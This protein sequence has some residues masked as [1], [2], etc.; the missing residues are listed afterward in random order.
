MRIVKNFAWVL[1]I[2]GFIVLA[3]LIYGGKNKQTGHIA[4]NPN[5]AIEIVSQT[6]FEERLAALKGNAVLLNFWA[7][8]CP[9]CVGEV[10]DLIKLH[11]KY[12]TKGFAVIGFS[13]D[14]KPSDFVREFA[15]NLGITYPVYYS[16][17]SETIA[18]KY[19]FTNAIPF[20]VIFDAAGKPQKTFLGARSYEE[21]ESAILAFLPEK[22]PPKSLPPV[23]MAANKHEEKYDVKVAIVGARSDAR[24]AGLIEA[25]EIESALTGLKA[26]I[27]V[28]DPAIPDDKK[29]IEKDFLE[30]TD[31]P[32]A[33]ACTNETCFPPT[34]DPAELRKFIQTALKT[35]NEK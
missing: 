32:T 35:K 26:V 19:G 10:P 12:S 28:L 7:T 6:D 4:P 8:W 29:A 23:G 27:K 9:P 20:T 1:I 31:T 15:V 17:E 14:T 25:A 33:H 16:Q 18:G 21:F 11:E 5:L 24:T 2:A 22:T 3:V 30:I 34:T 13:M